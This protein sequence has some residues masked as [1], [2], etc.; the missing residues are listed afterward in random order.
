MECL[1]CEKLAAQAKIKVEEIHA[2]HAC[3]QHWADGVAKLK[4]HTLTAHPLNILRATGAALAGKD[5]F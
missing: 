3:D 1:S 2:I 5:V 4:R